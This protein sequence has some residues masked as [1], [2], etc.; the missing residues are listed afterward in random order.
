MAKLLCGVSLLGL[1]SACGDDASP[2]PSEERW[3]LDVEAPLPEHLRGLGLF[4]DPAARRPYE[5]LLPFEPEYPL[6]SNGLDKERLLYLPEGAEID[7][8]EPDGWRFPVGTVLVKTFVYEGSPVETRVLFLREQGWDYAL[9]EWDSEGGDAELQPGNWPEKPVELGN[10]ELTHTLPARLDCRTC[11]ET[12]EE[13]AGTAVL[14]LSALQ[15]DEDLLERDVFTTNP[16]RIPV[17]G[18]TTEESRAFG[19]FVGNCIACHNGGDGTNAAFSL[20]PDEAIENTVD[21]PTETESGEGIRIVPGSPEQSVLYEAV[22]E[23][24]LPGYRGPFKVMP[25]LGVN[26]PDPDAA[27]ILGAWIEEL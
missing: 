7:A 14:G 24:P 10:G 4:E 6:Y 27:A 11:H 15:F 23:A 13:V 8:T 2:G 20:Y 18:R 12:H 26:R 17:G 22:V 19:Y 9:Y 3:L 16:E 25:P 21:Q 5:D 1:L